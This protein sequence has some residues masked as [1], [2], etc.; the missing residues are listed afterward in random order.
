LLARCAMISGVARHKA[1][2]EVVLLWRFRTRIR[3][4]FV[5][6]FSKF[7]SPKVHLNVMESIR[8]VLLCLR[9]ANYRIAK[10]SK[11]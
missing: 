6:A 11:P 4:I 7:Q 9:R 2:E 8:F 10:R 1:R 3:G 5:G